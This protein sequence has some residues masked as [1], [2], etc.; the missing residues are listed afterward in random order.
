V[1]AA[2]GPVRTSDARLRRSQALSIQ[3][4]AVLKI[5]K[6]LIAQKLAGQ[7]SLVRDKLK[8]QVTADMI[9]RFRSPLDSA[10]E[11]VSVRNLE[12]QGARAYWGAWHSLPVNFPTKEA[13]RIP[14]HWKTFGQRISQLTGS[15]HLATNAPN[16]ILNYCYCP[17]ENEARLAASALGLCRSTSQSCTTTCQRLRTPT[18]YSSTEYSCL[19]YY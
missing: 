19:V 13:H 5:A 10:D 9:A 4:G 2:T 1:L 14:E 16:A 15:P 3:T 8:N 17:L 12:S 6:T 18:S 7:E 11:L